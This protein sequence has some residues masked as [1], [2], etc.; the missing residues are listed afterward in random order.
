[1]KMVPSR[2]DI[3]LE[4]E[5]LSIL[6]L[7]FVLIVII[8]LL[9]TSALRIILGAPFVLFFPGYTL[10][11]ALFP[12]KDDIEGIERLGLS[13]GLSVA[14]LPLMGLVLNYTPFGI[15]L[16]TT[17]ISATSFMA[18]ST[19]IAYY[20]RG[21]LASEERFLLRF[22]LDVAGWRASGLVDRSLTAALGVSIFLAVGTFLFVV[23]KPEVGERFTEFYILGIK[24][25]A[26]DYP[27][28]VFPG[29]PIQLTVGVVNREHEDVQ[30]R[31]DKNV[32]GRDVE[33]IAQIQLAHDEKWEEGFTFALEQPGADQKLTFNLYKEGQEDPYRSLHLWIDVW[34]GVVPTP[35]PAPPAAPSPTPAATVAPTPT[36]A[37][38][39]TP[40]VS[41]SVTRTSAA[42]STPSPS[43][44]RS[45]T[46]GVTGT[47]EG[48]S[49]HIVQPGDTISSIARQYGVSVHAIVYVNGLE[50]PSLIYVGQELIIPGP[51]ETFPTLTPTPS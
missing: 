35:T 36:P 29:E 51:D 1:M 24:G 47:P 33:E 28:E 3:Q 8:Y 49:V 41:P 14:V 37:R 31:V 11:A 13:L 16:L 10:V 38:S 46:P 27:T 5:L 32:D 21:K 44:T 4:H 20:R 42:T 18:G 50:D 9:P 26:E 19:A 7:S 30:Y 22:E 15:T 12:G 39:A 6:G 43:P 48:R 17:L 25:R 34:P 23:A 45:P 2:I 40:E